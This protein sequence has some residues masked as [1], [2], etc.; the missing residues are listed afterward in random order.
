MIKSLKNNHINQ[1]LLTIVQRQKA[2]SIPSD[3][4]VQREY[5]IIQY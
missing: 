1:S 2:N 4:A 5:S 3:T